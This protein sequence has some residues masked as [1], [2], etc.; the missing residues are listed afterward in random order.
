MPDPN[1]APPAW[2]LAVIAL[3]AVGTLAAWLGQ[4]G[5]LTSVTSSSCPKHR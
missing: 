3:V 1:T 5:W 4:P 2:Q